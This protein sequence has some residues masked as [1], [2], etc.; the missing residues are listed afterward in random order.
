LE[1]EGSEG[2]EGGTEAMKSPKAPPRAKPMVPD[3]TVFPGQ[4]SIIFCIYLYIS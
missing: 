4:D 3:M 1:G 2:R